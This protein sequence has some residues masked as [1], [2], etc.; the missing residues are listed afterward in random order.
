MYVLPIVGS[1]VLALKRGSV[2]IFILLVMVLSQVVKVENTVV[3]RQIKKLGFSR[4]SVGICSTNSETEVMLGSHSDILGTMSNYSETWNYTSTGYD[5]RWQVFGGQQI[6]GVAIANTSRWG[7]V[8]VYFGYSVVVLIKVVAEASGNQTIARVKYVYSE[9]EEEE[10]NDWFVGDVDADGYDDI[11]VLTNNT[12]K[13]VGC[14]T[15]YQNPDVSFV[16]LAVGNLDDDDDLEIVVVTTEPKVYAYDYSAGTF[17]IRFSTLLEGASLLDALD[18]ETSSTPFGSYIIVVFT[19]TTESQIYK[20]SGTN[21]DVITSLTLT[22]EIKNFILFDYDGDLYSDSLLTVEYSAGEYIARTYNVSGTTISAMKILS[23]YTS[24]VHD[25][26]AYDFSDSSTGDELFVCHGTTLSAYTS[27][28]SLITELSEVSSDIFRVGFKNMNGT[29]YLIY[30]TRGDVVSV[31]YTLSERIDRISISNTNITWLAIGNIM[32]DTLMVVADET[33]IGYEL[34]ISY[35][36]TIT[37]VT[38]YLV[39]GKVTFVR[40]IQKYDYY[41]VGGLFPYVYGISTSGHILWRYAINDS[42]VKARVTNSDK[43]IILIADYGGTLHMLNASSGQLIKSFPFGG[44]I[45]ALE[46]GNIDDNPGYEY[47][48]GWVSNSTSYISVITG[49]ITFSVYNYSSATLVLSDLALVSYDG[50]QYLDIAVVYAVSNEVRFIG[51]ANGTF[52]VL[53]QVSL[54]NAVPYYIVSGDFTGEGNPDAVIMAMSSDQKHTLLYRFDPTRGVTL[55]HNFSSMIFQATPNLPIKPIAMFDIDRD[56]KDDV[57]F[58]VTD[59]T[60]TDIYFYVDIGNTGHYKYYRISGSY[61]LRSIAFADV[62]GS[63]IEDVICSVSNGHVYIF[64]NDFFVKSTKDTVLPDADIALIGEAVSTAVADIDNDSY[65]EFLVGGDFGGVLADKYHKFTMT[66]LEPENA[67]NIV[68][69][70][71][72]N[73]TLDWTFQGDIEIDSFSV[74]VNGSI[75]FPNISP[76]ETSANLSISSEG[77]W[78]VTIRAKTVYESVYYDISFILV[79]DFTAPNIA[80]IEAPPTYTN[81]ST[82]V[83]S[84]SMTDNLAGID[85]TAIILN[86]SAFFGNNTLFKFVANTSAAYNFTLIVYDKANNTAIFTKVFYVDLSPPIIW[87]EM[88]TYDVVYTNDRDFKL[89]LKWNASDNYGLSEIRILI[90]NQEYTSLS[91]SASMLVLSNFEEGEHIIHVVAVDY[92]GNNYNDS[93]RLIVDFTEP[94]IQLLSPENNSAFSEPMI[95]ISFMVTDTLSGVKSIKMFFDGILI[96]TVYNKTL[97]AIPIDLSALE[98]PE[99]T[100]NVSII[101]TDNAGNSKIGF[102]YFIYD[103]TP[104]T[105]HIESPK[106]GMTSTPEVTISWFANDSLSGIAKVEIWIGDKLLLEQTYNGEYF[107]NGTRVVRLDF[108]AHKIIVVVRDRAGNYQF[109]SVEIK[110]ISSPITNIALLVIMVAAIVASAVVSYIL[111][112]RYLKRRLH[113]GVR[114]VET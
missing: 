6:R 62:D 59:G 80:M 114:R 52:T 97:G 111:F 48:V 31:N 32:N 11:I 84:W 41:V 2:L 113:R 9:T 29:K 49:T 75:V 57:I 94:T 89:M 73:I 4:P 46:Y 104:P 85:K 74:L 3:N 34:N 22:N 54:P 53:D 101:V 13:F 7:Q 67:S 18:L 60:Y 102:T 19:S 109:A 86:G 1:M 92:A 76:S 45:Y 56:S 81:S 88:P 37:Q 17:N 61:N 93:V 71:T 110:V 33:Q 100:H 105:V 16:K 63:G 36:G 28:G 108:G 23:N 24:T 78:N 82:I 64:T 66:I 38:N 58:G 43:P 26:V 77:A 10:I 99:G 90:D 103:V 47:I 91:P 12:I 27:G 98:N 65:G 107:V 40:Y 87:I 14:D 30:T 96:Q 15:K 21:G 51:F 20:L 79:T 72:H 5:I 25:I 42:V 68:Y 70:N 83:F 112:R 69:R 106:K 55:L 39:S 95:S 50:D 35:D 44:K 8:H